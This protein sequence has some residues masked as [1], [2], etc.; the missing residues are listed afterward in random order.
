MKKKII[1][2]AV[3]TAITCIFCVV[4]QFSGALKSPE[5]NSYDN[6][7]TV[8]SN[9]IKPSDD[10]VLVLVNQESL[11]WAKETRGWSWPWP[12]E[13][14]AEL[15]E[16]FNIGNANSIAFDMMF[17]E[18]SIYGSD[19]DN[20]FAQAAEE[21]GRVVQTVFYKSK[22]PDEIPVLPIPELKDSAATI[23]TVQS[24]FDSDLVARRNRF[25]S[26]SIYSEPTL[27]VA[28]YEIANGKLDTSVIP[29]AK[30]GGMYIRFQ[31]DINRFAPYFAKDIL[32]SLEQYNAGEE[33]LLPPE[34]FEGAYV[35]F[36]LNAPGLF[37]ICATPVSKNYPGVGVHVCQLDTIL[38]E[39]Y[40]H[41]ISAVFVLLLILF[42]SAFGAFF[43]ELSTH[44]KV[45]FLFVRLGILLLVILA[46]FVIAYAVFISGIILP[47]TAPVMAPVIA[48]AISIGK[49]YL[50]EGR[51]RRYLKRAFGQYLSPTVIDNLIEHPESLK[52]GGEKREISVYFSDIQGFTSISEKLAP[53]ELTEFLNNYLTQMTDIILAHGGTIDKYEGDAIIA[54]WNAPSY[55][56]DH[57]KRALE[58]AM[59]CQQKLSE[60]QEL[61]QKK[62]GGKPVLQRIGLNTGYAVVGNMGSN[63]RFDYTMIG[64]TVNLASRLEG[65]NKQFA[66]YTMCSAATVEAAV[67][68]G[69]NF[70]FRYLANVAVVGKTEGVRVFEPM[71][72][73]TYKKHSETLTAFANALKTFT[74]GDFKKAKA[75]FSAISASDPAAAKY[76]E[77]CEDYLANPP[78]NWDGILHATKK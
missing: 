32:T 63:K 24:N 41:N 57:A 31:T 21:F 37:D 39:N 40:L 46:Y 34:D 70:K 25:Y 10:I 15:I 48:Y 9:F 4:L 62:T 74:A 36:G 33:P 26:P 38:N 49:N 60:M 27:A 68:Q 29:D 2:I 78:E 54:F 55:Q 77:K 14:Y 44:G 13:A 67:K 18:P 56:D 1:S 71:L 65:M 5:N 22:D 47:V 8:T 58:A 43:G 53:E 11:N 35:F 6:R 12:R 20:A 30:N 69:C 51:Q 19:D 66:T 75:E 76:V 64:D 61:L 42:T 28:S 16:Y 73:E 7:M 17:T 3:I 72:E 59:E 45:K 52:L 23:G 50:G